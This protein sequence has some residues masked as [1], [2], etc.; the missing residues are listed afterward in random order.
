MDFRGRRARALKLSTDRVGLLLHG[1]SGTGKTRCAALMPRPLVLLSEAQGALTLGQWADEDVILV[2]LY[3][4][5]EAGSYSGTPEGLITDPAKRLLRCQHVLEALH[6][7]KRVD[8]GGVRLPGFKLTSNGQEILSFEHHKDGPVVESVVL[9][10]LTEWQEVQLEQLLGVQVSEVEE[11]SVS[12]PTWGKLAKKTKALLRR[13]R[14]VPIHHLVICLTDQRQDGDV[15]RW[16]PALYGKKLPPRISQY[17][18]AMGWLR[19]GVGGDGEVVFR[20]VFEAASD[21][22]DCKGCSGLKG[23]EELPQDPTEGGP[24]RW[25]ER[26]MA[27]GPSTATVRAEKP[28][29]EDEPQAPPEQNQQQAKPAGRRPRRSK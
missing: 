21:R 24:A 17:F 28:A 26:I 9:D 15:T 1:G 2:E 14:E 27:A 13:L 18:T 11:G 6:V 20:A 22:V 19:K 8:G 29:P 12:L 10:S 4:D 7:A 23:V 25:I 16:V 5:D 3:R